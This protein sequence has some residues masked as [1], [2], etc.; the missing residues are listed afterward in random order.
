MDYIALIIIYNMDYNYIYIWII[1]WFNMDT[2]IHIGKQFED[3]KPQI[4]SKLTKFDKCTK[5]GTTIIF[6][7]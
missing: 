2:H 7:T 1:D 4:G 6:D 5:G 3:A